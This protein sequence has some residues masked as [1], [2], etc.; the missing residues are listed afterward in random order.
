MLAP[1]H[2]A[3]STLEP[4]W[5]CATSSH[6]QPGFAPLPSHLAK[7]TLASSRSLYFIGD[8]LSFQHWAALLVLLHVS[9]PSSDAEALAC[10]DLSQLYGSQP[11]GELVCARVRG[12][13]RICYLKAGV[14]DTLSIAHG[15]N[16]SL[17][18]ALRMLSTAPLSAKDAIIANAGV[19][20]ISLRNQISELGDSFQLLQHEGRYE[21]QPWLLWRETAPVGCTRRTAR[22][23]AAGKHPPNLDSIAAT[24]R[25]DPGARMLRVY[26]L[27][28]GLSMGRP[29]LGHL[30]ETVNRAGERVADC[31]HWCLDTATVVRGWVMVLLERLSKG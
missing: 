1:Q 27:S 18:D 22:V 2:C 21:A 9:L 13:R 28:M 24:L 6:A 16:R 5:R 11:A 23:P 14:A 12:T 15:T 26:N 20:P 29:S 4:H 31:M 30:N 25:I 19:H 3:P 8:S 10:P 7:K 17:A